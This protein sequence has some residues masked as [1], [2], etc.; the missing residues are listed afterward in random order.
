MLVFSALELLQLYLY[1]SSDWAK[2][3][4]VRYFV[5]GKDIPC[6]FYMFYN[7]LPRILG[8]W[9]NKIGQH[10]LLKDLHGRSLISDITGSLSGRFF[11]FF[12]YHSII[13]RG[14]SHPG[15]KGPDHIQLT[16]DVKLAVTRTL[17]ASDGQLSN[18]AF[19]LQR[20]AQCRLLW[21]CHQE[22][23]ASALLIWHIATEYCELAQS[24][25]GHVHG[26][27]V[28]NRTIAGTLSNYCA[29]LMAFAPELLPDHQLGTRKLFDKVRHDA[30]NMLSNDRTLHAKYRRMRTFKEKP[31]DERIFIKGIRLGKQLKE[32]RYDTRWKILADFW[33]EMIL[34]IAPSDNAKAHIERLANGGEF[35]T[36]LWALLFH[37]GIVER[38]ELSHGIESAH[39]S[40]EV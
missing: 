6:V 1:L 28:S 36:H 31:S 21:A 27:S 19:S 7:K 33:T 3:Q 4:L 20:N 15:V 13:S 30:L 11:G 23:H 26:R 24:C 35:L 9:Q 38:D 34:Y 22:N 37:A 2:V 32:I 29:Y 5:S 17:K 14:L 39:N 10:S 8:Y 16:R 40:L 25:G 12:E 18:G